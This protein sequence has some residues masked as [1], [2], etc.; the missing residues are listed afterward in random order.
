MHIHIP[1]ITKREKR[2]DEVITTFKI[3]KTGFDFLKCVDKNEGV[4]YY[5]NSDGVGKSKRFGKA[6]CN[7]LS[8]LS[9]TFLPMYG[10]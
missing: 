8:C 1:V 5:N 6:F 7:G 4:G 10:N 9:A 3:I 2:K